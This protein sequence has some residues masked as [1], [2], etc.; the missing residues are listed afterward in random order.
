[1]QKGV[2]MGWDE[3]MPLSYRDQ[4][5]TGDARVLAREI[6]DESVDLVLTDPPF[7][8]GFDYQGA[9]QDRA[10]GYDS[11]LADLVA[12][13]DRMLRPGG[14]AAFF[15]AQPQLRLT[16]GLFPT[17]SRIFVVAKNFV[18]MNKGRPAYAYD[19]VVFWRKGEPT[20]L[21][22]GR[23]WFVADTAHTNNRGLNDAG[24]HPC[25]RPL[26]AIIY[27]VQCLSPLDAVVCD[28]C[29]GSGTTA[30]AA[31]L[32]GRHWIGFEQ[33]SNFA[34]RARERVDATTPPLPGIDEPTQVEMDV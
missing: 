25:P 15:Q 21:P 22:N 23:D 28:L 31:K 3:R 26:D 14:F 10:A 9:Y 32:L 2:R 13:A 34:T 5:V 11:L 4:I 19:P 24:W 30:V 20:H 29:I 6:P 27:L 33:D 16:W 7:G 1:M 17:H 8:I 12:Q 18:Q